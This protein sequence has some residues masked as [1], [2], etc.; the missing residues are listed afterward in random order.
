LLVYQTDGQQGFYY[1]KSTSATPSWFFVGS[2]DFMA[3]GSVPMTARLNMNG[4]VL[5]NVST[6]VFNDNCVEIGRDARSYSSL[7]GSV[8]IGNEATARYRS[9]GLAIGT[10]ADGDYNGIA[11]GYQSDGQYSNIAIGFASSAYSGYDRV[12]IGRS[13]TNRRNDSVA[14]RGTLYLDGGTGVLYRSTCGSGTWRAKAFTID[15]P[16]DPENKVLRHFCV[17]GPEVW[18]VYAGNAK[19]V[20]GRAVI[21]LPDYYSALNAVGTEVYSLTPVGGVFSV[22]IGTRVKDNRF[23][24]LGEQDGDVSWTVKVLRN[25]P[26][27]LE[28][29]RQRPVEQYKRDMRP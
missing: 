1:N 11:I 12:A 4:N 8:A 29:I 15:H 3:N 2:G 14:I 25:D 5:T 13:V 7:F 24:I 22:G 10:E 9:S 26:A 19:L 6:I 27:C 23:V 21:D 18:N 17:E 20:N 16:L 28:D